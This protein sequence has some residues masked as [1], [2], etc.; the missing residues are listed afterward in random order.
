MDHAGLPEDR[1][2]GSLGKAALA[3][4]SHQRNRPFRNFLFERQH[5]PFH[6]AS[7]RVLKRTLH[8]AVEMREKRINEVHILLALLKNNQVL[9]ETLGRRGITHHTVL[10]F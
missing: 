7:K 4:S 6:R 3:P 2:Q 5:L 10:H 1:Y 9:A 8:E